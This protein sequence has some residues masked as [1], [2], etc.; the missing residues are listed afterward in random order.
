MTTHYAVAI[1]GTVVGTRSSQSKVYTH[2]VVTKGGVDKDWR[3]K[4][5][6]VEGVMSYHTSEALARTSSQQWLRFGCTITIRPVM[7]TTKR[8]KVGALVSTIETVAL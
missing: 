8:V 6:P 4:E 1:D 2:A 5:Y 7:T 3:G